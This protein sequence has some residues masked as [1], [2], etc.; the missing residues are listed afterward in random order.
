MHRLKVIGLALVAAFALSAAVASSASAAKPEWFQNKAVIKANVSFEGK[1]EGSATLETE[2]GTQVVCT[3]GK[4]SGEITAPKNATKTTVTFTGCEQSGKECKSAGAAEKEIVTNE[5]SGELVYLNKSTESPRKVGLKLKSNS[6]KTDFATFV[7]VTP[8][9]NVT[10]EVTGTVIGETTPIN[11]EVEVG[12]LIFEL[13]PAEGK[14]EQKW[15]EI[16]GKTTE[17]ISLSCKTFFTE[18][19]GVSG[20]DKIEWQPAKTKVEIS[21]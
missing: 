14:G 21:A 9:G 10:E 6:A 15:D 16:E 13:E 17:E 8:L 2:N 3:S 20:K 12:K 7:C 1:A 11:E 18:E 19:C 4:A 5:L